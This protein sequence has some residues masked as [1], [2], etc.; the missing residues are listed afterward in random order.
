MVWMVGFRIV[1]YVSFWYQVSVIS[2]FEA[3]LSLSTQRRI[4]RHIESTKNHVTS[5]K[6]WLYYIVPLE[7]T[8]FLNPWKMYHF[9]Y[10]CCPMNHSCLAPTPNRSVTR[11]PKMCSCPHSIAMFNLKS[12]FSHFL[13]YLRGTIHSRLQG[14]SV[15]KWP[16]YEEIFAWAFFLEWL[17][18][19]IHN[20]LS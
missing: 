3:L 12:L 4:I 20:F 10:C 2:D 9:R 15:C 6:L 5:G 1:A 19:L 17:S 13:I 16:C 8:D 18:L 7:K 11:N 14:T